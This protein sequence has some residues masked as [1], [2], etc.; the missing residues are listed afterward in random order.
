MT[1]RERVSSTASSDRAGRWEVST[2]VSFRCGVRYLTPNVTR[3]GHARPGRGYRSLRVELDDQLLG[4]RGVDLRPLRQGV[5]EDAQRVRHDLQPSGDRT[6]PEVLLGH[7][8]GQ[9]VPGLVPDVDDVV[10]R[11]PVARDVDLLAVDQEVAVPHELAGLT[12]GLRQAGAVDHGVETRLE[13]AQ[14]L[15]AGLALATV[16]LLVVGAHL[17]LEQAVREA[18][19]LLLLQLQQVLGLLDA[20]PAVLTRGVRAALEGLVAADQVDLQAAGLAGGWSC[21]ASHRVSPLRPRPG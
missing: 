8:E 1:N 13:Q 16:R 21:V 15:V 17:L 14:E 19:L 20:D 5:D 12:P 4:D 10:L 18:G 6:V 9:H 3:P 11:D 7:H 2:Y